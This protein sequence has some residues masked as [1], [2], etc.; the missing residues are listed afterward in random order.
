MVPNDAVPAAAPA[1]EPGFPPFSS[2]GAAK[3]TASTVPSR[4]RDLAALRAAIARIEGTP[5]ARLE[6]PSPAPSTKNGTAAAA[7]TLPPKTEAGDQEPS[8]HARRSRLAFHS[9]GLAEADRALGG[10]VPAA[11][12]S[13]IHLDAT[14]D[15]GALA[16]F[17]LALAAL[18]GAARERP[19]LWI[20]DE[21]ALGEAGRPYL[22]GLF[23]FGIDPAALRLVRTRRLKQAIWAGEEAASCDGVAVVILEVRGNPSEL[24]L[25]G[26]RRL[27][28]RAKKAGLPFLLLRQNAR[29]EA[30]A[31][32][33][34]LRIRPGPA[35]PVDDLAGEPR[36]I[37]HPVFDVAVEKSRAGRPAQLL[38]EWNPHERCFGPVRRRL[39][40]PLSRPR[41][42]PAADGPDPAREVGTLVAF[43]RAS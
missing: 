35:A 38:L 28:L 17:A 27:Q 41:L 32:P 33:L 31:A 18:L 22:P 12:L 1:K 29:A 4:N 34:R 20:A 39:A 40:V 3:G 15:G 21:M 23:S 36:L 26:T 2:C 25:E 10:G 7:D 14:R 6:G 24:A 16:G 19:V 13:E 42:S 8:A 11:G 9:L 43:R 37:G 30:T 5:A